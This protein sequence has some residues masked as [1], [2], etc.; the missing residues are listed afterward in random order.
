[1]TE[2]TVFRRPLISP[3]KPLRR[4]NVLVSLERGESNDYPNIKVFSGHMRNSRR[5]SQTNCDTFLLSLLGQLTV[6]Q[7]LV[8]YNCENPQ[9]LKRAKIR[10]L[11]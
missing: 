8:F 7:V 2:A 9:A 4:L 11:I 5:R 10:Y 6:Y 1:M 3:S